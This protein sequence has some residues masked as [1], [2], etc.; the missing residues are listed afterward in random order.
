M[1]SRKKRQA[2]PPAWA[3][4]VKPP[5]DVMEL[6]YAP[7]GF[8]KPGPIIS[9]SPDGDDGGVKQ[10]GEAETPGQPADDKT[11]NRDHAT[12]GGQSRVETAPETLPPLPRTRPSPESDQLDDGNAIPPPA[13]GSNFAD[14]PQGRTEREAGPSAPPE[15]EAPSLPRSEAFDKYI[16]EWDPFLTPG[17]KA[18]LRAIFDMTL[19]IDQPTCFT[20]TLKLSKA[21]NISERHTQNVLKMLERLGFLARLE[22]YNMK[23]KQGTTIE[24]YKTRNT[25]P[26]KIQTKYF[27]E[28]G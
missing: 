5:E 18:V 8:P 14:V 7:T 4:D 17:Q 24:L 2:D 13:P 22:V 11:E 3:E 10:A 23:D 1:S 6:F 12:A 25:T 26:V 9:T 19:A 15:Q 20:S 28:G 16:Q 27:M 21:A